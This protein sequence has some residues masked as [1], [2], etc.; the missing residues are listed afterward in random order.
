MSIGSAFSAFF[1][2]LSGKFPEDIARQYGYIKASTMAPISVAPAAP[3]QP[4]VKTSDGLSL[5][6][7]SYEKELRNVFEIQAEIGAGAFGVVYRAFD[8]NAVYGS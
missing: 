2:L 4:L 5:W 7:Q 1:S 3:P 8:P 6:S